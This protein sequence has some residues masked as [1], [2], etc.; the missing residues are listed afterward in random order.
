[1]TRNLKIVIVTIFKNV[2]SLK[3]KKKRKKRETNLIWDY[4][5]PKKEE[6]VA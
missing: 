3:D 5:Y 4:F 6:T 2:M 1:M